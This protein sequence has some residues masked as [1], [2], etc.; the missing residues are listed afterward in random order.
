MSAFEHV[1]AARRMVAN[2]KYRRS[3]ACARFLAE[4]MAPL[5]PATATV[6]VPV[7]RAL[8]RRIQFGVDPGRELAI[9]L[10]A[11][12]SLPVVDA[13]RPPWWW[14]SH[15]GRRRVDRGP[16]T[17]RS[18]AAVPQGAVVV[19]DVLTTGATITGAL[20]AIG[21]DEISVATATS[22]G[23]MMQGANSFP[24]LGGGVARKRQSIPQLF[25]AA[26]TRMAPVPRANGGIVLPDGHLHPRE[27]DG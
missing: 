9:A 5:V 19:D 15:A 13:L 3:L 8:A 7:P 22:A 23:R 24:A 25:T 6:V 14:R 1:G 18:V 4:A 26:Q 11:E 20:A 2:L 21:V 10:A 17:F 16:V 12:T 27:E